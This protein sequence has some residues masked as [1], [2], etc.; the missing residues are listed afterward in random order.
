MMTE[1][2]QDYRQN[3][4]K[5][6]LSKSSVDSNPLKQFQIWFSDIKKSKT[7]EE[8]NAMTLTTLGLDGF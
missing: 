1:N 4:E 2:L 8:V 6:K 3:Y 5:G 7:V